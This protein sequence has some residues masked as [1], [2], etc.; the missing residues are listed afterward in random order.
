MNKVFLVGRATRDPEMRYMES[1]KCVCNVGLATSNGKDRDP[2]WH[3]LQFWDKTAQI[4][5]DY[6]RKGSQIAVEGRIKEEQWDDKQTGEKRR[7]TVITCGQVELLGSKSD[8]DDSSAPRPQPRTYDAP[9]TEE[10]PF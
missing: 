7:K 3:N 4:V 10:V 8:R 9:S 6:V 5:A 1:G 2:D